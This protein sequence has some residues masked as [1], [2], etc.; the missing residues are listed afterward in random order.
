VGEG[1]RRLVRDLELHGDHGRD[2]LLHQALGGA[3]ERVVAAGAPALAGVQDR[4][5][6][7]ALVVQD[8]PQVLPAHRAAPAR[9]VLQDQHPVL[10]LRVE[11]PVA[12]EVEDVVL[13][14]AQTLLESSQRSL[15]DPFDCDQATLLQIAQRLV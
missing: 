3:G 13:A 5:A 7:R 8:R 9:L 15:F 10:G 4:Q 14:A 2:A 12:D 1:G 6:Q 11:G